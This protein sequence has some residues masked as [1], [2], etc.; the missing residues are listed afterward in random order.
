[1]QSLHINTH[2]IFKFLST[3]FLFT[4]SLFATPIHYAPVMMGDITTFVPYSHVQITLGND[5]SFN[6]GEDN[7]LTAK[8]NYPSDIVR[9]EWRED[10][11]LLGTDSTLPIESLSSGVHHIILTVIDN[12]GLSTSDKINITSPIIILK[13]NQVLISISPKDFSFIDETNIS[14]IYTALA[15]LKIKVNLMENSAVSFSIV[16][17]NSNKISLFIDKLKQ[18]YSIKYNTNLELLT[19]RHYTKNK[20]SDLLQ[21]KEVLVEQKT[22]Y[23]ARYVVKNG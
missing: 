11:K 6:Q 22:R 13:K 10:G 5:K 17:D 23:T 16:T 20:I 12:N 7:I 1:V 21:N 18:Y 19:V 9:Y 8:V 14:K 4:F 15:E 2:Q 3:I